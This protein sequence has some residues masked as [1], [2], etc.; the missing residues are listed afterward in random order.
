MAK[1]L[2][3]FTKDVPIQPQTMP[4]VQASGL[5]IIDKLS[6][7]GFG[8]A[9]KIRERS[10]E[11]L[12]AEKAAAQIQ[13]RDGITHIREKVLDPGTF[14][15]NAT[16]HYDAQVRGLTKGIL[17]STDP[18]IKT[19]V[20]NYASYYGDRN[21]DVVVTRVQSLKKNQLIGGLQEYL[22]KNT[23]DAINSKFSDEVIPDPED[24]SKTVSKG[25][26][27]IAQ[28][29][30]RI[31]DAMNSGI[32]TPK[33]AFTYKE[34]SHKSYA[35]AGYL[36]QFQQA[37]VQ[38]H[39]PNKWLDSLH[40]NKSID[41]T[42]KQKVEIQAN[43]AVN[44]L[45]QSAQTSQNLIKQQA[46]ETIAQVSSGTLD[47]NSPHVQNVK[48]RTDALP[49]DDQQGIE[50]RLTAASVFSVIKKEMKFRP[51]TER[52][53]LLKKLEPLPDD[54]DFKY[55]NKIRSALEKASDQME[56]EFKKDRFAYVSNN[57]DVMRAF[58]SRMVAAND[59][60]IKIQPAQLQSID[61][62][63]VALDKERMMGANNQ[64]LSVMNNDTAANIVASI[65]GLSD[66]K[67]KVQFLNNVFDVYGKYKN[68]ANR[69]LKKAGAPQNVLDLANLDKIA[70]ARPF[71]QGIYNSV[72]QKQEIEK[73][74][75]DRNSSGEKFSDFTQAATAQLQN[76]LNTFGNTADS[77]QFKNNMVDLTATAAAGYF[78]AGKS[79]SV[80]G[81]AKKMADAIYNSRYSGYV[82]VARIPINVSLSN[83]K[84]AMYATEKDISNMNFVPLK[85]DESDIKL[86]KAE[87]MQED[88]DIIKSGHWRTI[89]DDSGVYWV[90]GH[91][92]TPQVLEKGEA[93]RLEIHWKD[94]Q[95]STSELH[96]L[97]AK[98]KRKKFGIF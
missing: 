73:R 19:A 3:Q 4:D 49:E 68:I 83:A 71:L 38:N 52:T 16:D 78:L 95:D 32:I 33:E 21:R 76:L 77:E 86:T 30:N 34:A 43:G 17:D 25:D 6:Q 82:G 87:Q 84:D 72:E 42:T 90:D 13:I 66:I 12:D 46:D 2:A 18:K 80:D 11:S 8:V 74:L 23:D 94:L 62:F 79:S 14:N 57:P 61:P 97:M 35:E 63:A 85:R 54:P 48:L 64:Q 51:Y 96:G 89:S 60:S 15:I 81:A 28:G 5:A 26:V 44:R 9:K 70:G 67:S 24:K 92:F 50:H 45:K 40:K 27:L 39:D 31:N 56:K 41:D 65:D 29:N 98:Y 1:E 69:D 55:K 36:H 47:I 88:M 22:S 10:K 75:K 7:F 91:G 37:I 20:A 53:E 58:D 93:H 59:G